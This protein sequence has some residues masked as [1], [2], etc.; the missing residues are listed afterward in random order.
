MKFQNL[1][2]LE[3]IL[4][5]LGQRLW[6]EEPPKET[7]PLTLRALASRPRRVSLLRKLILTLSSGRQKRRLVS[8]ISPYRFKLEPALV[9]FTLFLLFLLIFSFSPYRLLNTIR[10][11]LLLFSLSLF[12]LFLFYPEKMAQIDRKLLGVRLARLGPTATPFQE[13]LLFRIQG[14]YFLFIALFICKL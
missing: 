10:I 3:G 5:E 13:I 2:E 9:T 6:K 14:L 12:S 11:T 1:D 4:K 7:I 8:G